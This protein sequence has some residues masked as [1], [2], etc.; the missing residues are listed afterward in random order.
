VHNFHN[1]KEEITKGYDVVPQLNDNIRLT[2]DEYRNKLY[3]FIQQT[4]SQSSLTSKQ[5]STKTSSNNN[6][7]KSEAYIRA[8][9]PAKDKPSP[10]KSATSSYKTNQQ[11]DANED[12]YNH[13]AQHNNSHTYESK[14]DHSDD[15]ASSNGTPPH[16]NYYHSS[17]FNNNNNSTANNSGPS[18]NNSTSS[19]SNYNKRQKHPA[20]Y[21]TSTNPNLNSRQADQQAVE[22]NQLGGV[23]AYTGV[24]F[25]RTIHGK[26]QPPV[27]VY[28]KNHQKSIAAARQRSMENLNASMVSGVV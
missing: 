25:G 26:P 10:L 27:N 3:Q 5:N 13:S 14:S 28:S 11:Q 17:T 23:A 2:I 6:Q 21:A 12:Y 19:L 24:A 4:K 15:T 18:Y 9:T 20:D 1:L 7:T 16:Q 22:P 8:N